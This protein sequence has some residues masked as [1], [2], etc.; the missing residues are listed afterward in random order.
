VFDHNHARDIYRH[1]RTVH[2][3]IDTPD[4]PRQIQ[5]NQPVRENDQIRG[6]QDD[7]PARMDAGLAQAD[8]NEPEADHA[9]ALRHQQ[10]ENL[11]A[12]LGFDIDVGLQYQQFTILQAYYLNHRVTQFS[13]SHYVVSEITES[14]ACLRVPRVVPRDLIPRAV[15]VCCKKI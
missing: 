6:N 8:A 10:E 15:I 4:V 13:L 9:Y 3:G 2:G 1:L 5:V 12:G 11:M 7:Q 14:I